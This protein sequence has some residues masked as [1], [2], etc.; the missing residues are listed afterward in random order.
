MATGQRWRVTS[1]YWCHWISL[2]WIHLPKTSIKKKKNYPS[3]HYRRCVWRYG[4]TTFKPGFEIVKF[5]TSR[6]LSRSS[7][8]L[9]FFFIFSFF[10]FFFCAWHGWD[11]STLHST[12]RQVKGLVRIIIGPA[13]IKG[14]Y[15]DSRAARRAAVL[16]SPV[17]TR[18]LSGA[19]V[20]LSVVISNITIELVS[21]ILSI[22]WPISM[23]C[24]DGQSYSPPDSSHGFVTSFCA[25]INCATSR[26][27]FAFIIACID[28]R[29]VRE[30]PVQL[31]A[32]HDQI[33]W[34]GAR[35]GLFTPGEVVCFFS[36]HIIY[37]TG[38][39]T[40]TR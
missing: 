13:N 6:L 3:S 17:S 27:I 14:V 2:D 20:W 8:L 35:A 24:L 36:E 28:R 1:W 31:K 19:A 7:S 9:S 29:V 12:R 38:S 18:R 23:A 5:Q 10:L 4:D 26:S 39:C 21:L 33:W 30:Q 11:S 40:E 32:K 37:S 25:S 34:L 16:L 22:E 15:V